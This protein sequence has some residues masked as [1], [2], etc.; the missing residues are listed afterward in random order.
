MAA[1]ARRLQPTLE[2]TLLLLTVVSGLVDAVSFVGL[3]QVF[4]ANMTGNVALL[5]FAMAGTPELSAAALV[6]SLAGF[7]GGALLGG[8]LG[9]MLGERRRSWLATALGL[10]AALTLAA[11]TLSL[12][13]RP[14]QRGDYSLIVLLAVA[15]GL[16]NATARRLAVPDLTTTVV[17]QTLTGLAADSPLAGGSGRRWRRRV[18]AVAALLLGALVGAL[19]VRGPG[20]TAGLVAV[21]AALLATAGTPWALADQPST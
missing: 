6:V 21:L 11:T 3:N 2:W 18:V 12:L 1:P 17:T 15:M 14:H 13:G 4:V 10:Q 20:L 7:L 16:Q 8:R 5:G 9:S 19:L